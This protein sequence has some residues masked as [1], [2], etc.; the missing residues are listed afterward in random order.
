MIK[1]V[2]V[3]APGLGTR[4]FPATKEQLY[5][6]G[7]REFC[8]AVGRGKR[9][10][11]DHFT[12]DGNCVVTLKNMGKKGQASDLESFYYKLKT[13]TLIWMNQPEP[14]GFGDAVLTS[15]PFIQNEPFLVHAGDTYIIS[16]KAVH[17][18][19]LTKTHE[20][21]IFTWQVMPRLKNT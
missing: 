8:F 10:I 12:P 16:R 3:P 9:A 18:K 5:D 2:V 21:L 6:V 1:K 20:R 15:Q 19:T 17:L 13:S 4:L 14:K 11:E 7:F